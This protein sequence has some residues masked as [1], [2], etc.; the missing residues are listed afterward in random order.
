MKITNNDLKALKQPLIYECKERINLTIDE[1]DLTIS[2]TIN[3]EGLIF[4]KGLQA[5]VQAILDLKLTSDI[6]FIYFKEGTLI[7]QFLN[8]DLFQFLQTVLKPAV[9]F[10][11][12]K[13]AILIDLKKINLPLIPVRL[14]ILNDEINIEF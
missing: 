10:T 3:I 9:W 13:K 7:N 4:Y 1:L 11:Y 5:H 2:D 14:N 6:V 12:Q 8:I